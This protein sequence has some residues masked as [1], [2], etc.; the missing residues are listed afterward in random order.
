M[1][2]DNV[3]TFRGNQKEEQDRTKYL[4]ICGNCSC[5]TFNLMAG[6]G[7]ECSFCDTEVLTGEAYADDER[8]WRK[9]IPDAPSKEVRDRIEQEDNVQQSDLPDDSIARRRVTKHINE[10]GDDN[11]LVLVGGYNSHGEGRW[12]MNIR[13]PEQRDWALEKIDEIVKW[14]QRA[15]LETTNTL[16]ITPVEDND[17]TD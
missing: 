6:G 8:M 2:D 7:I 9:R 13:T 14:V 10:W 15:N 16:Q 12:W 4:F 3:V 11:D 5:R 17:G 1:S